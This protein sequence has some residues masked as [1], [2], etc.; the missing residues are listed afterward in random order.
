VIHL[1][2]NNTFMKIEKLIVEF[3]V[4]FLGVFSAQAQGTFQNLDFESAN[5]SA[6][7]SGQYG[8]EVSLS[9]ALPEWNGSIGS[10]QVTQV[11]QNDY[12]LGTAS[13]DI[14]GPNWNSVNPGIISGSYTVFLQSGGNPYNADMP[15][16]TSLSQDGAI[17]SNAESLHFS[18]WNIQGSAP[19]SV[20]FAGHSLSLVDLYSGQSPSGQSYNVY[21]AN[22]A[23]YAGQSGQLE[24]TAV[25][26]NWIE[27][28]DISFSP[29]SV[30]EPSPLVLTGA[31]ALVF[32]LYR[33]FAP[34]R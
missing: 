18:A 15:A 4:V 32:A 31:G 5:L 30:P 8:G 14:F 7:P 19:L 17:P 12:T 10:V 26:P 34:K 28:D 21:G 1:Y 6:I 13:I 25:F 16:N 11:L 29:Q 27:L 22:V 33:R 2:E 20:S 24:F 23:P 3:S 9:S